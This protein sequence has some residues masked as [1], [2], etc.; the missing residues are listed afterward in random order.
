MPTTTPSC[1][2]CLRLPLSSGDATYGSLLPHQTGALAS[3]LLAFLLFVSL[4]FF[5]FTAVHD[6]I[7][8]AGSF[9]WGK[10]QWCSW[11]GDPLQVIVLGLWAQIVY[12]QSTDHDHHASGNLTLGTIHVNCMGA[13]VVC[14]LIMSNVWVQ[15][16]FVYYRSAAYGYMRAAFRLRRSI[17]WVICVWSTCGLWVVHR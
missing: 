1:Q 13:R 7:R 17:P 6:S 2:V 5:P 9:P 10:L 12:K 15:E 3:C 11:R 16:S 4:L 8:A 14:L